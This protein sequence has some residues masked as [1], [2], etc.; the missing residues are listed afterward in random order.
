LGTLIRENSNFASSSFGNIMFVNVEPIK[1]PKHLS[2]KKCLKRKEYE[3][4]RT[5]QDVWS[6]KLLQVK[7]VA[8][9]D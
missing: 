9:S 3:I 6:T 8:R 5:F 4:H 2:K 1:V 7:L